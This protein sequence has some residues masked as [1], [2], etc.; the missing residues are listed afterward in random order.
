MNTKEQIKRIELIMASS[1]MI[2]CDKCGFIYLPMHTVTE[3]F[4]PKCE[5]DIVEEKLEGIDKPMMDFEHD[6]MILK[7]LK[8]K[9]AY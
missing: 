2:T 5:A 6:E 9:V 4:C 7:E 1:S 8:D 3:E